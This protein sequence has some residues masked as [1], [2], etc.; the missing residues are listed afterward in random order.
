MQCVKAFVNKRFYKNK[1]M[2]ST[3][4][5]CVKDE[6]R[7]QISVVYSADGISYRTYNLNRIQL[8]SV[9]VAFDRLKLNLLKTFLKK[10]KERKNVSIDSCTENHC[11]ESCTD[12]EEKCISV[13]IVNS[14]GI[15]VDDSLPNNVAWSEC[16][17]L[18]IGSTDIDI[19]VN[20]P[21][22][23]IMP[24]S[25]SIMAG[26]PIFPKF[27]LEFSDLQYCS[28]IWE[29]INSLQNEKNCLHDSNL[30]RYTDIVYTPKNE[31]VGHCVKLKI[32]PGTEN[33]TGQDQ[34]VMSQEVNAGPGLC[35]FEGRHLFTQL[36]T[37]VDS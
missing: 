23:K 34:C 24:F 21:T 8:E 2:A 16:N 20:L 37:D 28:F 31:D 30:L 15:N 14:R 25:A 18:R 29:R 22:V 35:P 36:K 6:E 12:N 17:K 32:I 4:V 13:T 19:Y 33:R 3:S 26:F 7:M 10:N 27:E 9:S 1:T 11:T 5:R